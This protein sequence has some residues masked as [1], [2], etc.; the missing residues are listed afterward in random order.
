MVQLLG[1]QLTLSV[2]MLHYIHRQISCWYVLSAGIT[3]FFQSMATFGILP[4]GGEYK[5]KMAA[6][7]DMANHKMPGSKVMHNSE[8]S[9]SIL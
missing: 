8:G 9:S 3:S 5:H 7:A 6:M 4:L 2:T 1:S